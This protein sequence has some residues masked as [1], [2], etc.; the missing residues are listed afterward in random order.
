MFS[1]VTLTETDKVSELGLRMEG[2]DLE[3]IQAVITCLHAT[4]VEMT[5]CVRANT[6]NIVLYSED[7]Q[8]HFLQIEQPDTGDDAISEKIT[9]EA[10]NNHIQ[11]QH[12]DGKAFHLKNISG[13]QI[14]NCDIS[15]VDSI[16]RKLSICEAVTCVGVVN[17]SLDNV[18]ISGFR[19][20]VNF[21]NT[22]SKISKCFFDQCSIGIQSEKSK[23]SKCTLSIS[24]TRI[25]TTY[26]GLFLRDSKITTLMNNCEFIDVPKPILV[27][28]GAA[29]RVSD[30]N[31]KYILSRE[32]TTSKEFKVL[33][34]EM[35]LHLATSENV[36][37]RTAYDRDEVVLVF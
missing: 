5:L 8:S 34:E 20:G 30:E 17:L 1:V 10:V 6:F 12:I 14:S 32:Y 36:A 27:N 15:T 13:V 21:S 9:V 28:K 7:E 25:K 23:N 19:V 2:C 3:S 16:D 31:C 29:E 18:S 37:H 35:N 22:S 26:Y 33:E 24:D 4:C 11:F